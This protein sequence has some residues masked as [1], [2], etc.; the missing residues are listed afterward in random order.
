MKLINQS[1]KIEN[2]T[3]FSAIGIKKTIERC[4]RICYKSESKITDDSYEKF[5]NILKIKKHSR[6]LEFATIHLKM[7]LI[8]FYRIQTLLIDKGKWN[9]IW[10]KY[11]YDLKSNK[12]YISTNYRYYFELLK[13]VNLDKYFTE[14]DNDYYPKRYIVHFIIN[15]AI[16]DEF[17][18]HVGLS[19]LAESTRYCNYNKDKFDNELTFIINNKMTLYYD[20][21]ETKD[22][23]NNEIYINGEEVPYYD[24][25]DEITKK[26]LY[27]FLKAEEDYLDLINKGC[28]AQEARDILPLDIKSELIS[29]GF[30]D[31][32]DNFFY[33]RCAKDA[34]PM[35][36]EIALKLQ[37]E[38]IRKGY[39][40]YIS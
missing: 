14:E 13:Y 30:A 26:F 8:E 24:D 22:V 31:A 3:V 27:S 33:R 34:H 40:S 23:G 21:I 7:S 12:V 17:R 16:M 39:I 20:N 36:R 38:F 28:K 25:K 37:D 18:T 4:A 1:F 10:I 9:D 5:V 11:N 35:A 29:C 32:W 19:H 6:A 15:R 2:Q